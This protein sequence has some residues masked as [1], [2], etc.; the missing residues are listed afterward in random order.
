MLKRKTVSYILIQLI[1]LFIVSCSSQEY[2][3]A[4]LAIQ[5]SD[6]T[7]AAEWLPKAME[8]EPNNPEIPLVLAIEIFAKNSEWSEMKEMFDRSMG[9]DPEKVIVDGTRVSYDVA[10]SLANTLSKKLGIVAFAHN[11]KS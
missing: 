5:Q 6:F 9:I 1:V 8:I 10:E 4:K 3:T 7:K 11:C 2:T